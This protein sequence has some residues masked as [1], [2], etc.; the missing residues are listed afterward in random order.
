VARQM[1]IRCFAVSVITDLGIPGKIDFLT[2]SMV[3]EA[4]S[5]AEPQL[6]QL[7]KELILLLAND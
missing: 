7:I 2:H 6:A 4:A 1:G 5:I 3:T